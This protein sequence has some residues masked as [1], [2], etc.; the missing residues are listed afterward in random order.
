ML[1]TVEIT[2]PAFCGFDIPRRVSS[3]CSVF[4][5]NQS[6]DEKKY[7]KLE[8][9]WNTLWSGLKEDETYSEMCYA[10]PSKYRNV[11]AKLRRV[12]LRSKLNST[13][14]SLS[15][16]EY[17]SQ[18]LDDLLMPAYPENYRDPVAIY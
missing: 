9:L 6:E 8:R 15:S 18:D 16:E 10:V 14:S 2:K 12:F 4:L 3:R 7:Q 5:N 13:H 11:L 1:Q 17:S